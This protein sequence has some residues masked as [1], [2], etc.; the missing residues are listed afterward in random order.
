MADMADMAQDAS[1]SGAPASEQVQPDTNATI[2]TTDGML[3]RSSTTYNGSTQADIDLSIDALPPRPDGQATTTSSEDKD[4]SK[5]KPKTI[6]HGIMEGYSVQFHDS[7][8]HLAGLA[9]IDIYGQYTRPTLVERCLQLNQALSKK[10]R[11]DEPETRFR[12]MDLPPELRM[13]VWEF[14]VADDTR[15]IID[16]CHDEEWQ[17]GDITDHPWYRARCFFEV[18][19][20][21][22]KQVKK[23]YHKTLKMPGLDLLLVSHNT[24]DEVFPYTLGRRQFH[25]QA[26][27]LGCA[28]MIVN[29]CPFVK[30]VAF[31]FVSTGTA[32]ERLSISGRTGALDYIRFLA[33]NLTEFPD[34]L[35]SK[36]VFWAGAKPKQSDIRTEER[37]IYQRLDL[38]DREA[39][40][41]SWNIPFIGSLE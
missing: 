7:P 1:T 19:G 24:Y 32:L 18:Y 4:A 10:E 22:I 17:Y 16:Y 39:G 31:P 38:V 23:D 27:T 14:A 30:S 5:P 34:D 15:D 41:E 28:E 13:R 2:T 21:C 11:Y 6:Y 35:I 37:M 40:T 9:V 26:A 25:I 3:P 36:V 29:K 33:G 20:P 8:A 12:I